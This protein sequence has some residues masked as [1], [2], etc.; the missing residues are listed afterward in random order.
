MA[1][2]RL[3]PR[4]WASER[5]ER[6]EDLSVSKIVPSALTLLGL[7]SGA[8]SI[9]FA[10]HQD[11]K[12]AV[13]AIFC[14]MIFDML[15]GRAARLLGADSRFGVQLDSLADLISFCL[16]PAILIYTWSLSQMGPAGWIAAL[17]FCVCGAIRLARFNV[18]TA[19]DEGATQSYPYFVGL[20]TPAA[21]GIMLLPLLLSFEFTHGWVRNPLFCVALIAFTSVLMVS[22]V[23]TPSLKFIRFNRD[24]RIAAVL[25]AGVLAP[26]AIYVPWATLVVGLL[27]YL[28]TIPFVIHRSHHGDEAM[29]PP[30]PAPIFSKDPRD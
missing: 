19:R 25:L 4:Q 3:T 2:E 23:P 28:A 11:W 14:A 18:E 9:V 22:R 27:I 24:D 6:L 20:P 16:A 10:L 12:A 13:T 8:T 21:A 26:L 7:C 17:I 29:H 30:R 15:D 1:H 5:L